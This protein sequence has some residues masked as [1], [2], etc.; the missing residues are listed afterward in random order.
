MKYK[1]FRKIVY[2]I[3][4]LI[5]L[6]IIFTFIMSVVYSRY[7]YIEAYDEG[8]SLLESGNYNEAFDQFKRIPNFENYHNVSE[9]LNKYNIC[10]RCGSILEEG[11]K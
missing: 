10:P 3:S 7:E 8:V 1:N 9:L 6:L 4:I 2:P 5:I 11:C